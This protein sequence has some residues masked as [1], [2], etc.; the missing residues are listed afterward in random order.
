[1]TERR[2]RVLIV[3]DH[4][5]LNEALS[6]ALRLEGFEE[7]LIIDPAE[8]SD[9]AVVAAARRFRP[10]VVL[11]DLHL[12]GDRLAIPLIAPL[13][14]L[15]AQ[16]LMLTAEG[17]HILLARCLEAG[18]D[19]IFEKSQ[20][21][22]DLICYVTDAALGRTVL[23]PAAREA[24]LAEL[25]EHRESAVERLSAFDRLTDRE[26]AVLAAIVEGNSADEI[27]AT[28]FVAV[29][30]VRTHIRAVLDK[31]GVNS[32]LAAV[33]LARRADWPATSN[34]PPLTQ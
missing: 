26:A 10:E 34:H 32:Q 33:A 1:M 19:G 25:R 5:L 17:D 24:L 6:L 7:I 12:G 21:F 14:E 28:Q 4:A 13:G 29:S 9:D 15:G 22:S 27:A 30:T 20:A 3:E 18:A 11:L 16:V 23:R 31:L 8:Q 2:P